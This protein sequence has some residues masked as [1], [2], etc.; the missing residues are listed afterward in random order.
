MPSA[1]QREYSQF[2]LALSGLPF[3]MGWLGYD[4]LLLILPADLFMFYFSRR[5]LH[6]STI[7]EGRAQ[8]RRLYLTQ[9]NVHCCV[10]TDKHNLI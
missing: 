1:S 7:K 4:Y 2:F 3:L 9:G 8:I 10:H 5:L 6:S